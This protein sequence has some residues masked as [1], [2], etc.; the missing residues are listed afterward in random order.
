MSMVTCSIIGTDWRGPESFPHSRRKPFH[1]LDR[2]RVEDWRNVFYELCTVARIPCIAVGIRGAYD[3]FDVNW[4]GP[5]REAYLSA[6][7]QPTLMPWFDTVGLPDMV[8]LPNRGDHKFDFANDEHIRIGWEKYARVFF[9]YFSG[10]KLETSPNGKVLC[11]WWGIETPTGHGFRNQPHAQRLLDYI[12]QRCAAL[13]LGGADHIVDHTWLKECPGVQ[14]FGVHDW[15]NGWSVP[16]VPYTI[17]NHNGVTTGVTVPSFYDRINPEGN[18]ETIRAALAAFRSAKVDYIL[19]E[20]GTNFQED[21][22]LMR[23]ASGNTWKLDAV[24]EHIALL[25][26]IPEQDDAMPKATFSLRRAERML[27]PTKPG[28]YTSPFPGSTDEEVLAVTP[29]EGDVEPRPKGTHGAFESWREEGNRAV[30][31]EVHGY[32]FAIPL[33]D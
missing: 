5:A 7:P 18:A 22:E 11:A 6:S 2:T 4:R 27:H 3:D 23:D 1:S 12:D 15:F 28:F 21:A 30:F 26:P 16:P 25:T 19:I 24:R 9:D 32:T 31:P 17:R 10:C 20:S 29:P 13:G 8:N 14:V 33:V